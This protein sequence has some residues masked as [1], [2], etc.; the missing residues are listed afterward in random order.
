MDGGCDTTS[1]DDHPIVF[2]SSFYRETVDYAERWDSPLW[3]LR[4]ELAALNVDKS[5]HT[6]PS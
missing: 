3:K 5:F 6:C 2:V 4:Q 1:T